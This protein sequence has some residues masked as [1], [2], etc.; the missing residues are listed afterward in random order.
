MKPDEVVGS[1]ARCFAPVPKLA[2][3]VFAPAP[4]RPLAAVGE[5]C[6]G[7]V[8]SAVDIR[9]VRRQLHLHWRSARRR[10]ALS[11]LAVAVVAPALDQAAAAEQRAPVKR[12][13]PATQ[14]FVELPGPSNRKNN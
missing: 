2:I 10:R 4:H 12:T 11:Q 13:V 9:C 8:V 1:E 5:H 7:L 14:I 6:A 3:F